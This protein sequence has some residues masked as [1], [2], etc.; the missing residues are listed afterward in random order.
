M[1]MYWGIR[2]W[3]VIDWGFILSS[4]TF[5]SMSYSCIGLDLPLSY[6]KTEFCI[7][8][9]LT[10]TSY[11]NIH[12]SF[13]LLIYAEFRTSTLVSPTCVSESFS[14]RRLNVFPFESVLLDVLASISCLIRFGLRRSCRWRE[15]HGG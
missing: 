8:Y 6:L 14:L 15:A 2:S 12:S 9:I 1:I 4:N 13:S 3:L 10:N 5:G 7:S 11:R